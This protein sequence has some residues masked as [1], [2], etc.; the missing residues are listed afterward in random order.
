M[1]TAENHTATYH[2]DAIGAPWRIDTPDPL[3]DVVT[4]AIADRIER[5]DSVYSRFREDSFVSRIARHPGEWVFPP[6]A[7]PLFD[8]YRTLYE[9]TDGAMSPLVGERMENLGY[10]RAYSLRAADVAVGVP[11][12]DDA[13]QWDGERLA[14][15]RPVLI[16]VGAAGKG[17]LVDLVGEILSDAGIVDYVVDASGDLVHR[18]D[19][20]L[21]VALE[22]PRDARKAIGVYSLQNAALCASASNRRA[23]GTGLHHIIDAVTGRPTSRVV[24]T[25]AMAPSG[26]VADGLS[27]ALFFCGAGRFADICEFQY[28]RMFANDTVEY[29]RQLFGD[30][31]TPTAVAR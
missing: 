25:W 8:L 6:D 1:H 22:H 19:A 14:T 2:F 24:A 17:Y 27:T 18:G 31:F 4:R 13:F 23:W 21:R 10:D 7:A 9:R 5:F 29:S 3:G 26:L 16:D 11:H 20:P 12:W 15:S 30:L 28:V